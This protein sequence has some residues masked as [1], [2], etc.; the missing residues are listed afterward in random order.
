MK[1]LQVKL[2]VLEN[3][4]QPFCGTNDDICGTR[5]NQIGI[6]CLP[7]SSDSSE[8]DVEEREREREIGER[9]RE[10]RE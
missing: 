2:L 4:L 9:E 6:I 3:C 7:I 8:K 1:D 5:N 10:V